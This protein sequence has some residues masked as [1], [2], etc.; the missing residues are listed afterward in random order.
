MPTAPIA[1]HHVELTV[2]DLARSEAWYTDVLGFEK[3]GGMEKEDH[4]VV[5][6]RAGALMVGLVGHT[7]TPASDS[8]TERRVGL[9]HV[10][11]QV[12]TADD[13]EQWARHLD[14][15]G[16]EHTEVKDGALPGTRVVIFRD[17]D[18]IQLEFY[19]AP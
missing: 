1:V 11:F 12:P 8:F 10:G 3:I 9:D 6:L 7:A 16:V 4:S 14:A 15:R 5:M 19:Y 18:D 17:P 13:V 2:S